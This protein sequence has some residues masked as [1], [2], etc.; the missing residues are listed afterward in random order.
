M[1]GWTREK[2]L[3]RIREVSVWK[4]GDQRAPHKPL[5]ILYAL[6]KLLEGQDEIRFRDFY[7]PFK[8]LLQEFGQPRK[9]YHPEFPFWFL[10]SEE[11]LGGRTG[12][13]LDYEKGLIISIEGLP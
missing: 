11:I 1:S 9:V 10:R 7:E 2:L 3:T 6:G 13:G 8:D 5:L 4:K 12:N